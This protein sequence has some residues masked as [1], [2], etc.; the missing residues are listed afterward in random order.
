MAACVQPPAMALQDATPQQRQRRCSRLARLTSGRGGRGWVPTDETPRAVPS[1]PQV[2]APPTMAN[3]A[4]P[5]P[6]PH[7]LPTH[8]RWAPR[9]ERTNEENIQ[10]QKARLPPP[11]R[12]CAAPNGAHPTGQHPTPHTVSTRRLA[13]TPAPP[14]PRRAA[15]AREQRG[16]L[17]ARRRR[18]PLGGGVGG[19]GAGA[20]RRA[21]TSSARRG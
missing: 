18:V 5:A 11:P 14:R 12:R 10:Q 13:A 21:L 2:S 19:R 9:R 3:A 16:L 20:P 15:A 4:P 6:R 17:P 7:T 1:P 8:P